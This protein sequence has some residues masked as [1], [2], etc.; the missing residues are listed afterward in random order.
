MEV[1][2][3]KLFK[4]KPL[5]WMIVVALCLI[6]V[7][8]V[9]SATSR[10]SF[11]GGNYMRP[12]TMHV[13]HL[14]IGLVGMVAVA[15]IPYRFFKAGPVILLPLAAALLLYLFATGLGSNSASRWI[16]LGPISL[17]PSEI[18]KMAVIM[19]VAL[20][21]SKLDPEDDL[22]QLHTF[23]RIMMLTGGFCLFIMLENLSTAVLL[24]TIVYLM[25]WF[26]QIKTRYL[27][28]LMGGA[29]GFAVLM[30]GIM[31]MVPPEKVDSLPLPSRFTTWQA[32]VLDFKGG[33]ENLSAEMYV[34]TIARE[35]PQETH[36]N[37][38]IAT[39]G[40]FGKGPGN[41]TERDF[42]QEASC[43]FIYAIIIEELGM[44]GGFVVMLLYL[45]LIFKIGG[46][47]QRCVRKFPKYLVMGIACMLGMQAMI[48][49]AVAV[50][51]M[52]VT[53]QPLPLISTGGTS[54]LATCVYFGMIISISWSAVDEQPDTVTGEETDVDVTTL[55]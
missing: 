31:L 51:L 46:V 18:A 39:S 53:G 41:S 44:A 14:A 52:P 50:G 13:I 40:I 5:F 29:V 25:M 26:G 24:A 4:G 17:Q 22:S 30:V 43:D 9:F 37:I 32:R 35:K 45:W 42:L 54:I 23:M 2:Y 10:M 27:L 38:A 55:I 1:P 7:V 47:A 36:A 33:E 16:D 3:R 19:T 20:M 34:N 15:N 11:G 6:S 28:S 49:M 8:E 21:L 48:N 12:V